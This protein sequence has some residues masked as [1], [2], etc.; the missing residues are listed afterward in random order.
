MNHSSLDVGHARPSIA[1]YLTRIIE[2]MSRIDRYTE[3]MD[4]RAFLNNPLVQDAVVRNLEIIC[5][6]R[7]DIEMHYPEFAAMHPELARGFADQ[8]R[9]VVAP[10]AFDVGLETVWKMIDSDRA[11]YFYSEVQQVPAKSSRGHGHEGS[12]P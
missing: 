6:A 8:V 5:E 11:G 10:G 12:A 7:R 9:L 2:A 4:E 3:G 1:D